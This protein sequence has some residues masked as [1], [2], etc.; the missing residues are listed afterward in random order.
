MGSG[1]RQVTRTIHVGDLAHMEIPKRDG[2]PPL[3]W[4]TRYGDVVAARFIIASVLSSYEYLL[5]E[6]ITAKEATRRLRILRKAY[7]TP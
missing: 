6:G 1:G 2:V 7:N 5:G 3:E 4:T